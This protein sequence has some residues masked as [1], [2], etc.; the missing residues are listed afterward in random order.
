[1]ENEF[2]FYQGYLFFSY[3]HQPPKVE[4]DPVDGPGQ[5]EAAQGQ[6]DQHEVGKQRGEVDHMP[7]RLHAL[8]QAVRDIMYMYV[9]RDEQKILLVTDVMPRALL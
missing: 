5:G 1:M 6:Q 7:A 9:S 3:D 8:Q 2:I 4:N